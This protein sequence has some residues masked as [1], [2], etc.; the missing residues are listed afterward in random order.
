VAW[1]RPPRD[2]AQIKNR[3]FVKK[4]KGRKQA[5]AILR[6]FCNIKERAREDCK[7]APLRLDPYCC[8]L[9]GR[10]VPAKGDRPGIGSEPL[11]KNLWKPVACQIQHTVGGDVLIGPVAVPALQFTVAP[12]HK[13]P[14]FRFNVPP[15][16]N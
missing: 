13:R 7:M 16:P 3:P 15:F 8:K 11:C 4:L 12:S 14:G 2:F 9:S 1:H 6:S 10:P 5:Q